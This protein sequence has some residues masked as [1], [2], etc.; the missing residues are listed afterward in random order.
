MTPSWAS[1]RA[2][3]PCLSPGSWNPGP[4]LGALSSRALPSYPLSTAH[5]TMGM[6][7]P[8]TGPNSR[9]PHATPEEGTSW[10]GLVAL[11]SIFHRPSPSCRKSNSRG[12]GL[13]TPRFLEEMLLGGGP[14]FL[15]S[16]GC[17]IRKELCLPNKDLTQKIRS[18]PLCVF[19]K[20][21]FLSLP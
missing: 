18:W 7:F 3:S 5:R 2:W 15:L 8:A 6:R 1:A 14:W 12:G 19:E 16:R 20:G 17:V 4:Q 9:H 21:I 13:L 11:W 10:R